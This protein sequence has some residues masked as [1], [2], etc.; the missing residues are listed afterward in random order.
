MKTI[1][2][3]TIYHLAQ[4]G[5]NPFEKTGQAADNVTTSTQGIAIGVFTAILV[6]T[7][8]IYAFAGQK[9]KQTMK[10]KWLQI[11]IAVIVVFGGGSILLFFKDFMG[12]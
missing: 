6:V 4:G 12:W 2:L 8:F 5:T 7:G 11:L 1:F 3:N 10:D 9:L